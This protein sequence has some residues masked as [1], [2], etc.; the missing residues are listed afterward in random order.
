MLATKPAKSPVTPPPTPI[1]K[2]DLLKFS[3][4]NLF[5]ILFTV[6]IDFVF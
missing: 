3:A 1:I 2:S 5:I 4:S 6:S